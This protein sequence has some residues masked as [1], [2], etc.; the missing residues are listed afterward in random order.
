MNLL[1]EELFK[2][3]AYDPQQ[4]RY[5]VSPQ[6]GRLKEW[7]TTTLA[8]TVFKR[9]AELTISNKPISFVSVASCAGVGSTNRDYLLDLWLSAKQSPRVDVEQT[10][11]A[12]KHDYI[13]RE[14]HQAMDTCKANNTKQPSG[15]ISHISDLG[16]TLGILAHEGLVYNPDPASHKDDKGADVYGAWGSV[17]FNKMYDGGIPTRGYSLII[18]PT[19]HGKSTLS[20]SKAALLVANQVPTTMCLNEDLIDAGETSRRIHRALTEM[21]AGTKSEDEIWREMST[22]LK[23]YDLDAGTHDIHQIDRFAYWDQPS[24]LILDSLDNLNF[25]KGTERYQDSE[26]HRVRANFLAS[27]TKERNCFTV[28]VGNGSKAEQ[29]EIRKDISKVTMPMAFGSIWY[30]NLSSWSFV[31]CRDKTNPVVSD[32]KRCKNRG[33]T[34][35][36]GEMWYLDYDIRGGYYS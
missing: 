16:T 21:W 1:E 35:S 6:S 32:I 14:S 8:V 13:I 26:R 30:N 24:V 23:V 9:I 18:G 19:G 7:V 4:A 12:I 31:F 27:M 15:V 22:Y 10:I 2:A 5:I 11:E 29:E 25:P 34:G 28:L 3:I 17:T 36:I 20:R 33:A